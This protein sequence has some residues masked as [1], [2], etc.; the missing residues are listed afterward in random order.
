MP[1]DTDQFKRWLVRTL[2]AGTFE[3]LIGCEPGQCLAVEFHLQR[4]YR[5]RLNRHTVVVLD[6]DSEAIRQHTNGR[7]QRLGPAIV[8]RERIVLERRTGKLLAA[9]HLGMAATAPAKRRSPRRALVA[10]GS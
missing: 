9:P 3:Q 4:V 10:C 7:W 8:R 1:D 5:V 6:R 2:Q